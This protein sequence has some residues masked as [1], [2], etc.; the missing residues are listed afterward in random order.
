MST[1]TDAR[2]AIPTT[3]GLYKQ[4]LYAVNAKFGSLPAS[5]SYEVVQVAKPAKAEEEVSDR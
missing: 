1:I 5:T 2:F 4:L 3:I